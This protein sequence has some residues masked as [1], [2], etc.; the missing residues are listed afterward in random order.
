[1][2]FYGLCHGKSLFLVYSHKSVS[3]FGIK[4]AYVEKNNT[5]APQ[6]QTNLRKEAIMIGFKSN[7]APITG[8]AAR[9]M[10]REIDR[11]HS[12]PK[13]DLIKASLPTNCR[14]VKAYQ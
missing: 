14:L 4:F 6:T 1:M 8:D 9:D 10:L 3:F 2:L 12:L 5:F 11:V 13:E 7:K